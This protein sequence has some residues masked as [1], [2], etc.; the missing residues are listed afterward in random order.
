MLESQKLKSAMYVPLIAGFFCWLVP[1]YWMAKYF[2]ESGYPHIIYWAPLIINGFVSIYLIL[3]SLPRTPGVRA[4]LPF[5]IGP[6]VVLFPALIIFQDYFRENQ[7]LLRLF[8]QLI[9]MP[10][11]LPPTSFAI[12]FFAVAIYRLPA[13]IKRR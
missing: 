4:Y 1:S 6:P 10:L 7:E 8:G 5:V 12:Q 2:M 13:I 11:T 9:A 3:Q